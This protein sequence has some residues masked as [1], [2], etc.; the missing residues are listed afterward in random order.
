MK[1]ETD[2]YDHRFRGLVLLMLSKILMLLVM[3]DN[4]INGKTKESCTDLCDD[5]TREGTAY[6]RKLKGVVL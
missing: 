2:H 4:G 5:A 3:R 6:M 1:I